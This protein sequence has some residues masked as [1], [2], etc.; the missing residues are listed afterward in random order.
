MP[1]TVD[2]A[3]KYYGHYSGN[4]GHADEQEGYFNFVLV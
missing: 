3:Q 1:D 2:T 4:N